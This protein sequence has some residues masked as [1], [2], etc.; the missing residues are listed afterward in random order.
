MHAGEFGLFGYSNVGSLGFLV[1]YILMA[2]LA[3]ISIHRMI[4][5]YSILLSYRRLMDRA[6]YEL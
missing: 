1:L 6:Y 5:M 2:K 3:T 4:G